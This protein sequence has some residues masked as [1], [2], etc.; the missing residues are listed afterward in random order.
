M[1]K[2]L[3]VAGLVVILSLGLSQGPFSAPGVGSGPGD[4]IYTEPVKAVIFSHDAHLEKGISCAVCHNGL[5]EMRA[6]A[7][8]EEPDFNMDALYQG[9][10]CGACHAGNMAFAANTECARCHIGVKGYERLQK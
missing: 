8:Q 7:A 3:T 9:Q 4:I 5:F 10:Y 6:L 1:S 2:M